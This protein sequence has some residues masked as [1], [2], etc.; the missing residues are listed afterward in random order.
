MEELRELLRR[1][2]AS[3]P[4]DIA[5]LQVANIEYPELQVEPFVVL[6]DSHATEFADRVDDD[7]PAEDFIEL[8]NAYLF[9]ELGFRG[10]SD[11]YYDPAN[12]CLNEVLVRRTGIPIT[13]SLIYIE[14][15]R[16][17]GRQMH[18]I[19]LPGHFLVMLEDSEYR[20]YIDPFHGGQTLT[21][22]ECFELAREATGM[23]L[24]NDPALLEPVSNR[25]IV[26]RMLNNLRA[27]Y[28]Q[29]NDA[30][31]AA[32]VLD[33]L[34]EATPDSAEEYKQR[35]VCRAQLGLVD[36]AREDLQTY[37]R[38]APEAQDRA[39]VLAELERLRRLREVR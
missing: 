36:S 31:R 1:D 15:A 23:D 12:S 32:K 17:V 18:G 20:A 34:I 14:I 21:E 28:F 2:A 22:E 11:N 6:L 7:T 37:L 24:G 8:L 10:N 39:Q 19:G 29:R 4:L 3:V 5:A 30:Q 26:L 27:V 9:E 35:G 38:L 25:H 13:L 16:R 33:L